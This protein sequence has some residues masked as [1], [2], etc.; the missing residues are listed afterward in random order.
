MDD[1]ESYR[2]QVVET[3]HFHP[4]Q[5]S[6]VDGVCVAYLDL[7]GVP[8][9]PKEEWYCNSHAM[10][11][12]HVM[13]AD[14]HQPELQFSMVTD[15][16]APTIGTRL[17]Q[18]E[19]TGEY[20]MVELVEGEPKTQIGRVRGTYTDWYV[21]TFDTFIPDRHSPYSAVYVA[22]CVKKELAVV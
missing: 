10:E 12:L 22:W 15:A 13:L 1:G 2:W 17:L 18:Y 11:S 7:M 19:A 14:L 8:H 16:S 5:A 6:A 21:D 3:I 4:T 9:L 20:A